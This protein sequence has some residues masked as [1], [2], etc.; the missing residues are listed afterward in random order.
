MSIVVVGGGIIGCS[1][2]YHLAK[3]GADVILV[4]RSEIAGEASGAAAGLLILPDRAGPAGP[5]RDL[6]VASLAAYPGLIERAQEESGVDVRCLVS[7]MLV[8]ARSEERAGIL[9]A[10]AGQQRRRGADVTWVD[11]STLRELEPALSPGLVGAAY[12][13]GDLNVDPGRL[14]MAIAG[15]AEAAG[16]SVRVG[17][18]LTGFMTAETKVH[19]V[20]TNGDVIEGVD[21]V[22]LAAGPWTENLTR[23]L[24]RSLPTPP[25]RGQ[26]IAYRSTAL[27]HAIW[28]E[29]GYLVPKTGGILYAGATV[30][31]VG[32]RKRTTPRALAGLRAM[33]A[34]L[35]PAL[36]KSEVVSEWAGLRPGSPDGMPVIGQVSGMANAYVATG[37]F[38]NGVLLAPITGS[39]V[40][41]MVL[42]GRVDRLL[43][44]FSPARF[45]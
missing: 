14:T 44:A 37:H 29:D 6:C 21:A 13:T 4:E 22:V 31:D 39:L 9:R 23:R 7:G 10:Y 12:S 34:G 1:I 43:K 45:G 11:A 33:A 8:T 2:A 26:M 41:Q 35:V 32:F 28:G 15:A 20:R 19:A 40:A 25:M 42:K 3:E 17:T 5:F 24:G 16:A 27:R 30:E 18:M 36:R 38:R